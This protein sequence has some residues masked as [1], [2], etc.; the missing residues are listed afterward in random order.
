MIEANVGTIQYCEFII[1]GDGYTDDDS[2]GLVWK[3]NKDDAKQ[4]F[5]QNDKFEMSIWI[6][7]ID[8][9]CDKRQIVQQLEWILRK[10]EFDAMIGWR[11]FISKTVGRSNK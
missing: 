11:K 6:E 1:D 4:L 7:I 3:L 10:Q 9:Q 5:E 8:F 2:D